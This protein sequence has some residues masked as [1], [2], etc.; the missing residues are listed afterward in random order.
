MQHTS[1]ITPINTILPPPFAWIKVSGGSVRLVA[2]GGYLIQ[3]TS[4]EA[5]PFAIAR[6]PV[7]N[8]QYQAFVDAPDG[9]A[10][11]D[12]WA[13]SA[14]ARTWR[15]ENP[16]PQAVPFGSDDAPRTHVT[17]YEAVAFCQW[18]SARTG[19]N[20]RLPN[21]VEWQRA[22]QGDDGRQYPWGDEWDA[23]RCHNNTAHSSI[24]PALVTTYA[25]S[26]DS[27]FGVADMAGN[28]WEWCATRWS[29]GDNELA[30]DDVRVLRGG[31]WFD[32]V[33]GF[34]QVTARQ[35]WNPDVTSDLRGFRLVMDLT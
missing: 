14:D 22:A 35:S 8:A 26:G 20:I 10:M 5:Q 29:T 4:F 30:G 6:Y 13:Y 7:T 33:M 25:G 28:V 3:P 1:P 2:R 9:Y 23:N 27:P 15:D 16:Q 11:A 12:W 32:S 31:S 17:W 18:L 24:G 19:A 34:F 21:E